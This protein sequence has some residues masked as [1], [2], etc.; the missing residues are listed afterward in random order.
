MNVLCACEPG[1]RRVCACA[2]ELQSLPAE[3][4]EEKEEETCVLVF[5]DSPVGGC[6]GR[7]HLVWQSV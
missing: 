2:R 5:Y 7:P 6:C 4:E 3:K 1:E